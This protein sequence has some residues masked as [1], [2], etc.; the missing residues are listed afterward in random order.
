MLQLSSHLRDPN[1]RDAMNA[2]FLAILE[3]PLDVVRCP[4][5]PVPPLFRTGI[6]YAKAADASSRHPNKVETQG[7]RRGSIRFELSRW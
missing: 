4:E 2:T 3:E 5:A 6:S 7:H 1:L